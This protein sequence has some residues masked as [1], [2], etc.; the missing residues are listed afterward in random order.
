M[1]IGV[2]LGGTKT[3]VIALGDN[4]ETLFRHRLPTPRDDYQGTLQTIAALVNEAEK[5]TGMT[6]SVGVGIPGTLSHPPVAQRKKRQFRVAERQ[7]VG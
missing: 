3:E 1:R 6:G 7:A 5:A 2:D 4:G